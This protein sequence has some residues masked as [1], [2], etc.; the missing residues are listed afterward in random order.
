MEVI[1]GQSKLHILKSH[2][3]AEKLAKTQC[4]LPTAEN[5]GMLRKKVINT[6][7]W[8]HFMERQ[9]KLVLRK[10]DSTAF[11]RT[12]TENLNGY[13]NLLEDILK[14]NDLKNSPSQIYSVNETTVPLD[15]KAT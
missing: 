10:G 1:T 8:R 2:S 3:G 13:F 9:N 5:K 15:L 7:W 6:G 14:Q 4:A 12:D 11:V